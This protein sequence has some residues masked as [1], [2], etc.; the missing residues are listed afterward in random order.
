MEVYLNVI[1]T[2]RGIYGVE[3]ASLEYFGKHASKLSRTQ[4]SLIA[5]CLPNPRRFNPAKPSP[6]IQRRKD[7]II[8]LMYKIPQVNFDD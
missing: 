7:Q 6:Y 2:G 3:A 8:N 5:V 4:A 1:E